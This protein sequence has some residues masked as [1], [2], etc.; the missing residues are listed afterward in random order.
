M[1]KN[2]VL[3]SSHSRESAAK[4][5]QYRAAVGALGMAVA[6]YPD[7]GTWVY[8]PAATSAAWMPPI[9]RLCIR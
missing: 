8:L 1:K 7:A 2:I 6:D 3:L 5:K 9:W 4:E